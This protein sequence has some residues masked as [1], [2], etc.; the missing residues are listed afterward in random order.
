MVVEYEDEGEIKEYVLIDC[1]PEDVSPRG[2]YIEIRMS[3]L[4]VD[5]VL[6]L[7]DETI[8]NIKTNLSE[9]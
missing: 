5:T 8:H 7:L 1:Y 6:K 3:N 9:D 2:Y 4:L